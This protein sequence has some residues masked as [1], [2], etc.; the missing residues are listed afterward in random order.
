MQYLKADLQEIS[1]ITL[2]Y[3][4]AQM[5]LVEERD[6]QLKAEMI[7]EYNLVQPTIDMLNSLTARPSEEK[8]KLTLLKVLTIFLYKGDSRQL[9]QQ[10]QS[11]TD[12]LKP[13]QLLQ[14]A[15]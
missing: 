8:T 5:Q 7:E 12:T 9:E 14:P 6:W 1:L 15:Y 13:E 4:S 10:T 2:G 3:F 11:N